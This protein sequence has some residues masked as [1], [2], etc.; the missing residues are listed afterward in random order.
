MLGR[1]SVL[2]ESGAWSGVGLASSSVKWQVHA[3]ASPQQHFLW[4]ASLRCV[5][6]AFAPCSDAEPQ[7]TNSATFFLASSLWNFL[8]KSSA[9]FLMFFLNYSHIF[10]KIDY[11]L[12]LSSFVKKHV[13]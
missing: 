3:F 7:Q 4:A 11:F 12:F 13:K 5:P 1:G 8:R 10:N 6:P 9:P 2:V